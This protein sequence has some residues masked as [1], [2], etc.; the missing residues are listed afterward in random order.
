ME[1]SRLTRAFLY[2]FM[3]YTKARARRPF[4]ALSDPCSSDNTSQVGTNLGSSVGKHFC[5]EMGKTISTSSPVVTKLAVRSPP[6]G[7]VLSTPDDFGIDTE[8]YFVRKSLSVDPKWYY[9][10]LKYSYENRH[11]HRKPGCF[12]KVAF[13]RAFG[14]MTMGNAPFFLKDRFVQLPHDDQ[15]KAI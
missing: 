7:G 14:N 6:T 15:D 8:Y 2:R 12:D 11:P 1:V 10:S 9:R 4:I 13:D 5:S 3:V